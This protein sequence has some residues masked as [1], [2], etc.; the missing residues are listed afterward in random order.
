MKGTV[1]FYGSTVDPFDIRSRVKQGCVL[2]A[3]LFGMFFAVMLKHAFGTAT[4]GVYL[5]TRSDGKLFNLSRLR[6]KTKVQLKCMWDFLF[7]DDVAIVAYSA[8]DLQQPMNR[9][10]MACQDFGLTV[11]DGQIPKY[12]LYGE[13]VQGKHPTGRPQ[14]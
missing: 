7:A 4:E 14:L 1:V 9:F 12:L 3:T 10:S 8:E 6:A 5:R 2:A 13:L 11:A